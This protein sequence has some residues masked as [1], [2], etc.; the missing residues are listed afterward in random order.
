MLLEEVWPMCSIKFIKNELGGCATGLM[1]T[2]STP[3]IGEAK[4]RINIFQFKK[5]IHKLFFSLTEKK[6]NL[7]HAAMF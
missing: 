7:K 2:P 4:R 5:E 3:H 1:A 6:N